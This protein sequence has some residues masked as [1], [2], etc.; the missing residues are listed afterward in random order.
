M[1]VG[2]LPP[3]FLRITATSQQQ[4]EAADQQTAL[5]LHQQLVGSPFVQN[6]AG[7]LNITVAQV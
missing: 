2:A 6:P 5:A 3:D 4:Q 7:R 1:Y